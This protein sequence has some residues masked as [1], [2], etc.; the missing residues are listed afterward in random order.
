MIDRLCLRQVRRLVFLALC[1][2]TVSAHADRPRIGLVLGGGGAR[3]AAHIGVL[4]ELERQRIPVDVVVGTSMGAIVGGLYASGQT[5][6]ELE[7]LVKTLDWGAALRDTPSREHLSFRRKLDDERYPI[8][9]ERLACVMA[10]S[11]C[12]WG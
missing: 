8:A 4:Q 3:G 12:R 7:T 6:E 5:P 2:A 9:A 1:I 11:Y 10:N